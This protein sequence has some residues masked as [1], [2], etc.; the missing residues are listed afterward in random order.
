MTTTIPA[1]TD[2]EAVKARET[3]AG[4]RGQISPL[5]R[6]ALMLGLAYDDVEA[7]A[8]RPRDTL[9]ELLRLARGG[10]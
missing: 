4:R 5:A 6:A 2:H 1:V 8:T 10:L 3:R 7:Y 9:D